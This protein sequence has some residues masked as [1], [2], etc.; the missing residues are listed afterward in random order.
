VGIEFQQSR[1]TWRLNLL[2][3]S[4]KEK[5]HDLDYR[6]NSSNTL[7]ARL[8]RSEHKFKLPENRE[9]GSYPDRYCLNPPHLALAWGGVIVIESPVGDDTAR[10]TAE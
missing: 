3:R 9:L 6:C 7:A 5:S 1:E 4:L 10:P 2:I 8:F